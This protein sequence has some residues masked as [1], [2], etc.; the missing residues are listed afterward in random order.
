MESLLIGAAGGL[1]V[2]LMEWMLGD[3]LGACLKPQVYNSI[4]RRG[5]GDGI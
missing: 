5:I 4:N 2:L 1:V 3:E